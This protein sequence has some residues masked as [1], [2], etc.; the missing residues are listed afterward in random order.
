MAKAE[1]KFICLPSIHGAIKSKEELKQEVSML[2]SKRHHRLKKVLKYGNSGVGGMRS[3]ATLIGLL[4]GPAI[5]TGGIPASVALAAITAGTAA[6]SAY[7]TAE[8]IKNLEKILRDHKGQTASCEQAYSDEHKYIEET[9]LPYI[10]RKKRAKQ[11]KKV[12][13]AST[14]G[15]ANVFNVGYGVLKAGY[16]KAKGTKGVNRTFYAHVLAEHLVTC[17]C[18]F[19]FDITAELYSEE[20]ALVI[21]GQTSLVAA[22]LLAEKMKST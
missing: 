6:R 22:Q 11:F 7:K 9:I 5:A 1:H 8:H 2:H 18:D 13:V 16:K 12:T 19:V 4:G 10:I 14:L 3:G 21:R 15:A 17:H 20:E